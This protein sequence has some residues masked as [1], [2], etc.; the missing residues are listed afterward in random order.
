MSKRAIASAVAAI[1]CAGPAHAGLRETMLVKAAQ[2]LQEYGKALGIE[3]RAVATV[4]TLEQL[5]SKKEDH[6][7]ELERK[8]ED[9]LQRVL[10]DPQFLARQNREVVAYMLRWNRCSNPSYAADAAI[11]ACSEIVRSQGEPLEYIAGAYNNRG[12]AYGA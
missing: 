6:N 10:A 4:H 8:V 5:W 1:L 2:L 7:D 11:E 3:L 9:V 12:F